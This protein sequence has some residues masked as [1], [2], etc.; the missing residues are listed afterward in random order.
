MCNIFVTQGYHELRQSLDQE[1]KNM[2]AAMA[3]PEPKG[4]DNDGMDISTVDNAINYE[5]IESPDPKG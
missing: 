5:V 1:R 2:A 4:G 3:P